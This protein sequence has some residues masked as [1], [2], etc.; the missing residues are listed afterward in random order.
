MRAAQDLVVALD[1]RLVQGTSTGDSTYWSGLLEGFSNLDVKARFLLFSRDPKPVDLSLDSR[2]EWVEIPSRTSRWWSFVS[3]PMAARRMGANVIH[4][5][6]SLSPMV[7]KR[8]V[9]TVHDVSF[10]IGPEWFSAKDRIILSRTV[11]SSIRRA[12]RVLAVSETCRKEIESYIPSAVGKTVVTPNACPSWIQRVDRNIAAKMVADSLGVQQPYF[13]TVGTRWPRKNMQLAV[14]A[15]SNLGDR[16]PHR[17]VITGKPGWG[18]LQLGARGQAVGYVDTDALSC[19]YSA[20]EIYLAPSRHE[21]FGIPL[22]EAFRCGCPVLCSS[23][24]ALPEVAGDAAVVERSWSASD[25]TGTLT[26]LVDDPSK[27][28]TLRERGLEREKAYSWAQTAQTT[29]DVYRAVA[30]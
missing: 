16:Y 24:G 17:L 4:T 1:A 26:K 5:Q 2:F 30:K 19:L 14:D 22:L 6:Y 15:V 11:P 20:A 25:W 9:T 10:L 13:L 29:F 7:G 8:G 18:E 23:G 27:L 3:F 28:Q 12:A 21:G